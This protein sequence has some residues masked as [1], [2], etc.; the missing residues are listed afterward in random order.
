MSAT[1]T[2]IEVTGLE[3]HS[4]GIVW[5]VVEKLELSI[6]RNVIYQDDPTFLQ[7]R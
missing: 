6:K 5:A 2:T 3:L 7:V 1:P 4:S